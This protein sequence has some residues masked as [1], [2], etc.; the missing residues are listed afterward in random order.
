MS[1]ASVRLVAFLAAVL[2]VAVAPTAA[3]SSVSI[4]AHAVFGAGTFGPGCTS[5][6]TEFCDDRSFSFH[7][8]AVSASSGSPAFGYFDRKNLANGNTFVGAVTCLSVVGNKVAVGGFVTQPSDPPG[9]P[10]L[11]YVTD[12]GPAGQAIDGISPFSI[13]GPEEALLAPG[14]PL[15]CPSAQSPLGYYALTSGDVIVR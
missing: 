15:V 3:Q 14:F 5:G 12:N 1:R 9:V 7:L 6:G 2:F 11:V 4:N 10:F 13:L 8:A